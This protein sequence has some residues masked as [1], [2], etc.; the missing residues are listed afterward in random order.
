MVGAR[1]VLCSKCGKGLFWLPES[2]KMSCKVI[3]L[4][5]GE[6]PQNKTSKAKKRTFAGSYAFTKKGIREDV[7]PTYSFKS[8]T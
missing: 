6:K 5:C 7:Q 3:C 4:D 1:V 2:Y 8:G